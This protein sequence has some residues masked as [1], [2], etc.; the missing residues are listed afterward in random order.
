MDKIKALVPWAAALFIAGVFLDSLRFKFTGSPTTEHI[1]TT[2]KDWSG[3]G[4]FHPAGPWII[5]LAELTAALLVLIIPGVLVFMGLKRT[6]HGLQW[7][8]AL[9]GIG[10]MTGAIVFH[11]FTPLGIEVPLPDS[12]GEPGGPTY[13]PALFYTACATWLACA[14]IL[15]MRRRDIPAWVPVM[16]NT[17]LA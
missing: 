7:L 14:L 16:G 1:F 5:G 6:A 17:Q 3:I 10:V 15:W 11:L 9:V 13:S 12:F 4:L 2:L 8:G